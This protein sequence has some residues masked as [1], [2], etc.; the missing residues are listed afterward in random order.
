MTGQR[1]PTSLFALLAQKIGLECPADGADREH[2]LRISKYKLLCAKPDGNMPLP[3]AGQRKRRYILA[4]DYESIGMR[5]KHYRTEK[6]LSQEDLGNIVAV[7]NEH[8][9]RIEG[10]KKNLSL[11]LLILIANALDVSADDLLTDNL[12]HSSSPVGTEIHDLLLDCNHDEKAILTRTLTFLKG[13]LSE[14]GI[15]RNKKTARVSRQRHPFHSW[16]L[17]VSHRQFICSRFYCAIR[18]L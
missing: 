4:V 3:Y 5:I 14:F 16:V 10:G 1:N 8:I 15:L 7:N 6:R 12:K 17:S 13:L 9:S 2:H 11:E 18:S